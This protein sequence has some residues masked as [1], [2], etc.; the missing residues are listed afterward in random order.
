MA[1]RDWCVV[2]L[3]IILGCIAAC[4]GKPACA[5]GQGYGSDPWNPGGA[6]V[7]E[8]EHEEAAHCW[9]RCGDED[10][11]R[12]PPSQTCGGF[13]EPC[14]LGDGTWDQRVCE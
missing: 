2:T 10:P 3:V 8:A 13:E 14:R 5:C 11:E 6:L 7:I 12:F 4:V 1:G 9:C